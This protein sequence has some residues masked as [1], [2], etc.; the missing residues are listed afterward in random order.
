[1]RGD[2][3]VDISRMTI[4]LNFLLFDWHRSRL[5]FFLHLAGSRLDERFLLSVSNHLDIFFQSKSFNGSANQK[6]E[7]PMTAMLFAGSI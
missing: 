1:M 4:S 2:C 7:L 5:T 3:F 6:P